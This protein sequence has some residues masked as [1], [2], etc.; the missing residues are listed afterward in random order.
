MC[1][2]KRLECTIFQKN[3]NIFRKPVHPKD[4]N[5]TL[6]CANHKSFLSENKCCWESVLNISNGVFPYG[7]LHSFT[8]EK[9]DVVY[10]SKMDYFGFD[11]ESCI[12]F[13][14]HWCNFG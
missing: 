3:P 1:S 5:L 8:C 11:C 9:Q 10:T 7:K 6:L 14:K 13:W 4:F 12:S 2:K